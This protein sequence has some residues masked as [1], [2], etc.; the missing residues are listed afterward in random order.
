MFQE[1]SRFDMCPLE[2]N[3]QAGFVNCAKHPNERTFFDHIFGI[4]FEQLLAE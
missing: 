3:I 2:V 4:G 1:H